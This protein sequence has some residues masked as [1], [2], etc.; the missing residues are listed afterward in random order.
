MSTSY[1]DVWR[2]E[3]ENRGRNRVISLVEWA[4]RGT[5]LCVDGCTL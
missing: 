3:V 5:V 4:F 1:G 2:R